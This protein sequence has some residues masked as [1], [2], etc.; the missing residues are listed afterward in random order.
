MKPALA[1]VGCVCAL[2]LTAAGW[3]VATELSATL[4]ATADAERAIV[5]AADELPGKVL[6]SLTQEVDDLGRL[7]VARTDAQVTSLRVDTVSVVKQSLTAADVKLDA[8]LARYDATL[9]VVDSRSG[10]AMAVVAKSATS[11]NGL[12]ANSSAL[13]KDIQ[14]SIDDSY[15]DAKALLGSATVATTQGAQ[16][17]MTFNAQFPAMVATAQKTNDSIAGIAGN[18]K[19]VTGAVVDIIHPPPVHG[20]WNHMKQAAKTGKDIFI[21]ALRGGA[22]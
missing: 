4:R 15:W 21:A 19:T 13:V 12:I 22:L 6:P 17:A 14:E 16:A 2:A 5:K 3:M 18:V 1:I 20:F 10:E 7:I 8:A 9:K 11:A